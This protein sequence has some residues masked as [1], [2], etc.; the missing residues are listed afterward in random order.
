MP[1]PHFFQPG[2][3]GDF[4]VVEPIVEVDPAGVVELHDGAGRHPGP[5]GARDGHPRIETL[6]G[7]TGFQ[8]GGVVTE[9]ATGDIG[10]GGM[11]HG[12]VHV[13]VPLC[14]LGVLKTAQG[15]KVGV[16]GSLD[17]G[18]GICPFGIIDGIGVV[19]DCH[20]VKASSFAGC[21]GLGWGAD[22]VG[23][24]GM[25]VQITE[26]DGHGWLDRGFERP[27]LICAQGNP[28]QSAVV[29]KTVAVYIVVARNLASGLR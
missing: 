17:C 8:V 21:Q 3:R 2:N 6:H 25:V 14:A 11:A 10:A 23:I 22:A 5:I 24:A 13:D 12:V 9:G 7:R 16:G 18:Q 1:F 20:E 27:D 4:W 29:P 26:I 28:A 15:H 19:G